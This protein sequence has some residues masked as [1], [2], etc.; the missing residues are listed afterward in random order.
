MDRDILLFEK[1]NEIYDNKIS[2]MI[3]SLDTQ[4]KINMLEA[5]Y[6]IINESGTKEDFKY[7]YMEAQEETK[8][9]KKNIFDGIIEWVGKIKNRIV[10]FFTKKKIDKK[11]N[12]LP[13]KVEV[14][15]SKKKQFSLFE[16][17]HKWLVKPINLFKQKRYKELTADLVMKGS[18]IVLACFGIREVLKT[19]IMN[20]SEIK[21]KADWIFKHFKTSC[22]DIESMLK[23][24]LSHNND[25]SFPMKILRDCVGFIGKMSGKA[26]DW[27][28]TIGE[29]PGAV[30]DKIGYTI[31]KDH[32]R[33][34]EEYAAR[35]K[36]EKDGTLK[37]GDIKWGYRTN[38]E[39]LPKKDD[40]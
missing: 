35:Y 21:Q 36:K 34:K 25:E 26:L 32:Q 22:D 10:D 37:K 12:A 29:L 9:K 33:D 40:K 24:T 23:N 31:Y 18:E 17:F 28:L 4:M 20:K 11:I 38:I 19:V 30:G 2:F 27:I 16:K 14:D 5:Q 6:K 7:L 1:M 13:D 3:E 15:E 8:E 39:P